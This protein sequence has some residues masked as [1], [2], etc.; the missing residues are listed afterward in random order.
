MNRYALL[1]GWL[2]LVG[3]VAWT[4]HQTQQ[5]VQRV[6]AIAVEVRTDTCGAW[7]G[8]YQFLNAWASKELSEKYAAWVRQRFAADFAA[9]CSDYEQTVTGPR[10]P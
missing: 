3:V 4:G 9:H 7:Q 10:Q 8:Q 1:T 5:N 2:L 6:E